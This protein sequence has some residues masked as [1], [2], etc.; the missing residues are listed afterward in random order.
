MYVPSNISTNRYNSHFYKE[1]D[2]LYA[3]Y[4]C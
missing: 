3:V 1:Y 2:K 4:K